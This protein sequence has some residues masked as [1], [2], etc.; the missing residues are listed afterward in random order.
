MNQ[1]V[2]VSMN[3][4]EAQIRNFT[5]E[6]NSQ[7]DSSLGSK[8]L[9]YKRYLHK[10]YESDWFRFAQLLYNHSNYAIGRSKVFRKA[11][12]SG[13]VVDFAAFLEV[14][15]VESVQLWPIRYWQR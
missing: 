2:K 5:A 14:E 6:Y 8:F 9:R 12:L 10:I 3:A 1:H 15:E 7:F 13:T 11:N 4:Y